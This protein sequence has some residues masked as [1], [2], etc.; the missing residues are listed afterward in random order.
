MLHITTLPFPV[1]L[2]LLGNLL[3]YRGPTTVEHALC[4]D[5]T[6]GTWGRTLGQPGTILLGGGIP[7]L[8]TPLNNFE[9]HV[10]S[11]DAGW[12]VRGTHLHH[13]LETSH[14]QTPVPDSALDQGLGS[15]YISGTLGAHKIP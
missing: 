7:L 1:C 10:M 14:V 15:D 4:L 13:A 8:P 5:S 6:L 3:G 2:L 12:T 9:P 11:G